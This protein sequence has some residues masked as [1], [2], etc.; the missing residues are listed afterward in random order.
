MWCLFLKRSYNGFFGCHEFQWTKLTWK[1]LLELKR[2]NQKLVCSEMLGPLAFC[3]KIIEHGG[4]LLENV[5][6]VGFL[7]EKKNIFFWKMPFFHCE[8]F[9]AT[10]FGLVLCISIINALIF[11][12][13]TLINSFRI[14]FYQLLKIIYMI[15]LAMLV[16]L[17]LFFQFG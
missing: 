12:K 2:I 13:K 8:M 16:K 11:I 3:T 7:G 15:N 5:S 17:C 1:L 4:T 9:C 10:N 14:S 6:A